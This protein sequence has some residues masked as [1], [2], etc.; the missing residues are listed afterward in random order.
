MRKK[1]LVIALLS[2]SAIAL[3]GCASMQKQD[4]SLKNEALLEPQT[5]MKFS[6][7]PVPA[8]LQPLPKDSYAFE[9]S[10]VRVGILKYRGKV[11]VGQV[12]NF[13]KEQMPLYNWDLLNVIEYGEHLLNF[14]RE[15]ESCIVTLLPKGNNITV[16]IALGPKSNLRAKKADKPVK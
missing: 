1:I 6:D 3:Y 2:Y 15:E 14:E 8:G 4:A 9:S 5:A 12:I 10:G 16:T 11:A 7:I 13:Y